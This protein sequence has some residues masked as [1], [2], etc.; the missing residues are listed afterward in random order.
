MGRLKV[1][2]R[3]NP[4][5]NK[6]G[7]TCTHWIIFCA[8]VHLCAKACPRVRTRSDVPLKKV[9]L[10]A[11]TSPHQ[12]VLR[13]QTHFHLN[14]LLTWPLIR[15]SGC[16]KNSCTAMGR[17]SP[18]RQVH[19]WPRRAPGAERGTCWPT[20]THTQLHAPVLR[21]LKSNRLALFLSFT[22]ISSAWLC[23]T[24]PL[25]HSD[26]TAMSPEIKRIYKD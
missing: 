6:I 17:S 1:P 12:S 14:I 25:S 5:L 11:K 7:L 8:R 13:M 10:C 3:D 18:G 26:Q 21:P 4:A 22:G 23:P 16:G 15:R 24:A 20:F 19:L 2:F 9:R